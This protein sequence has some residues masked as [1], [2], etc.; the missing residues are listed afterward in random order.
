MV[1]GIMV[2]IAPPEKE[3]PAEENQDELKQRYKRRRQQGKKDKKGQSN[4][5]PTRVKIAGRIVCRA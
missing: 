2:E 3:D 4:G 5:N 1:M